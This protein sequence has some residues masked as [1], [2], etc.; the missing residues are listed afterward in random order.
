[1]EL[2]SRITD[3][4]IPY[5]PEGRLGPVSAGLGAK[6]G[7]RIERLKEVPLFEGGSERQLRSLAK[8]P[9]SSSTARLTP[10]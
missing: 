3:S 1:V 2:I 7:D 5:D 8:T 9:G 10:F 6:Q 4:S